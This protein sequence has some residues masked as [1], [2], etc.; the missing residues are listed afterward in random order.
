M[1][2]FNT[3]S[4]NMFKENTHR[5]VILMRN[6]RIKHLEKEKEKEDKRRRDQEAQQRRDVKRRN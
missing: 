2:I 5:E 4:L 3:T 1:R 6:A